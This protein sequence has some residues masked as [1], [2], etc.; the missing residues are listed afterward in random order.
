MELATITMPK[1]EARKAF[2][3]YRRAVRERHSDEDAEIMRA[4]REIARGHQLLKV[5]EAL[6]AGGTRVIEELM[7]DRRR[8]TRRVPRLA[9]ARA[10]AA[11]AWTAGI[12]RDG[13]LEIR[14]KEDIAMGNRR[15]RMRFPDG[16]FPESQEDAG[17]APRL[18]AMVPTVP[19]PLRPAHHLRNY[20]LLWEAEWA[21]VPPPPGD[22]ALLKR[23]SG[24]LFAVVAIWD[25]T[26]VERAV[27][28]GRTVQGA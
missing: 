15:D 14:S 13:A 26:E 10:D 21:A 7:W 28:A 27:L 12:E 8:R 25:L 19:P 9:I 2:L 24:D 20:H 17:F 11:F 5:S 16:T 6:V 1:T 23:I 22:P 3:E 4:Y 18:R